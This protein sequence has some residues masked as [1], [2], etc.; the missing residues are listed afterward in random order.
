MIVRDSDMTKGS[1]KRQEIYDQKRNQEKKEGKIWTPI[2]YIETQNEE[3]IESRITNEE[4]SE[5]WKMK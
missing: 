2:T 5:Q 3:L 1:Q 4:T